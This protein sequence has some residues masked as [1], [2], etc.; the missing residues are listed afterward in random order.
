M[1]IVKS[2]KL[3][4]L[5]KV[6]TELTITDGTKSETVYLQKLNPVETETAVRKSNALR[7]QYLS[8]KKDKT[9]EAYLSS[10]NEIVDFEDS[11][12][13]LYM[14]NDE[15]ARKSTAIEAEWAEEHEWTKDEYLQSLWD[16]WNEEGVQE[17]YYV[18]EGEEPDP[19]AK[20]IFDEMQ[21]YSVALAEHLENHRKHLIEE[22]TARGRDR[23]EEM[24][25]ERL[26]KMQG[27]VAWM[28]EYR[29]CEVWM[30]TR[31]SET[32][33][34]PYFNTRS[35]VDALE[36]QTLTTLIE[37]MV[38]LEVD[39]EEGKDSRGTLPSSNSSESLE[40]QEVETSSDQGE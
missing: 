21:K 8:Q 2:R 7:A 30:G 27:D 32:D 23:L 36:G 40:T 33:R 34:T 28:V 10:L 38:E 14:A 37:A 20:R 29:K 18:E 35:E 4:E 13:I 16:R 12:L 1:Q 19:E 39:V 3:A 24:M 5:F 31:V 15:L 17:S 26:I 6:G 22:F 9:S 25:V 11:E